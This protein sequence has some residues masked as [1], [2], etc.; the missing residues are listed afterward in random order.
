MKYG[1]LTKMGNN[2]IKDWK[3]RWVIMKPDKLEYFQN[4]LDSIPAG[5][6]SL[7]SCHATMSTV[8]AHCMELI[9][10]HRSYWFAADTQPEINS[11]I[12]TI[13]GATAALM[14][15]F[16]EDHKTETPV[17]SVSSL[18]NFIKL[19]KFFAIK[20]NFAPFL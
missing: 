17:I 6:I 9:T 12:E 11:W 7:V 18:L 4:K 2:V 14:K 1:W 16:M 5:I 13:M 10:P 3:R 15:N 19:Y 20:T 8:R